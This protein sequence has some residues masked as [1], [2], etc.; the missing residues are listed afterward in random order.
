MSKRKVATR[1]APSRHKPATTPK[2]AR[3]ANVTA[4]AQHKKQA[5]IRGPKGSTPKG[6]TLRDASAEVRTEAGHE[7]I[8]AT[9][10]V[11]N[12]ARAAALETILLASLQDKAGPETR[13]NGPGKA[14]DVFLPFA[15][16]PAYQARLMELTQA[17]T[18][19]AFEFI[20]RLARI[21]SPLEFW[22]VIA[23]FT[24]RRIMTIGK[25]S[26]ELAAFWRP[27]VFRDFTALPGR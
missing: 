18:Q 3:R 26:K 9:P 1:R 7:P 2:R 25:D 21:R 14:L 8:A 6:R 15:N 17:N 10:I 19:F 4:R 5:L 27:D 22:A 12:R 11:D 16:M 23:E 20:L 24:A 13:D